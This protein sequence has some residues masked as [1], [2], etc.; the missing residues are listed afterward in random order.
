VGLVVSVAARVL[1]GR[2]REDQLDELHLRH[3]VEDVEADKALFVSA[4]T[5]QLLHRQRR[6]GACQDRLRREDLAQ[7]GMD[8]G[9]DGGVLHDGLHDEAGLRQRTGLGHDPHVLRVHLRAEAA[10]GLLDRRP[11]TVRRA[12]RAGQE[13][14]RPV[15]RRRCRQT[16][17]DRARADDRQLL[18]HVDTPLCGAG[19]GPMRLLMHVVPFAGGL[20]VPGRAPSIETPGRRSPKIG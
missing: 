14:H 12:L 4:R 6:G 20:G 19:L 18:V 2:A 15:V 7:L 11:G 17:R 9:L 13:Q 8:G 5:R 1:A 10:E 3:R 16:A